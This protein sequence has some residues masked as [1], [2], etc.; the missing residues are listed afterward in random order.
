MLDRLHNDRVYIS[1]DG[2][3]TPWLVMDIRLALSD[4]A[5]PRDE[6]AARARLLAMLA[7]PDRYA[8]AHLAL[9][10]ISTP[11]HGPVYGSSIEPAELADARP[12][13]WRWM[14]GREFFLGLEWVD[15]EGRG[16][17]DTLPAENMPRLQRYWREY[18]AGRRNDFRVAPAF[19][20][21]EDP[22]LDPADPPPLRPA[23][24]P[25]PLLDLPEGFEWKKW[26]PPADGEQPAD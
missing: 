1:L 5:N 10:Q 19:R 3:F 24:D 15:K 16:R 8:A 26:E 11:L 13:E 6:P 7:D 25:L 22:R 23:D 2:S 20:G 17:F 14:D 18:F 4:Y 9:W 12:P 21:W